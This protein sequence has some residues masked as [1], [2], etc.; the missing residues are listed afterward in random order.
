MADLE[1]TA[2][3][4]KLLGGRLCLDFANTVDWHASDHPQE[5]LNSYADL[6]GWSE[7]AGV[8]SAP[9]AQ[10]LLREAQRRPADAT[11]AHRRA[12]ALRE[13][14]YR[15]FSSL[16]HG[17]RAA[18]D[19][20]AELHDALTRALPQLRLAWLGGRFTWT[21]AEDPLALDRMLW[22]VA[23][24]AARLLTSDELGRVREC[25]GEGCGWL[26][27]DQSRNRSRRWCAMEDCGNR[28]KARR[29]YARRRGKTS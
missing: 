29:Y 20:L 12:L 21:W 6:V 4:L 13:A 22:P 25:T 14:L 24:S 19:D 1:T 9:Q 15:L 10:A 16:A 26:F 11:T 7:H 5:F 2:A 8:L 27:L 17:R 3:A 28:A 23:W 18:K